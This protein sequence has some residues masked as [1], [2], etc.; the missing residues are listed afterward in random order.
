MTPRF[1]TSF[2]SSLLVLGSTA[3]AQTKAP[4]LDIPA[5]TAGLETYKKDLGNDFVVIV[6]RDGKDIYRKEFGELKATSQEAIGAAS[7]WLTAA[8]TMTFVEEGKIALDD[9]LGNYLPSYQSYS[10]GW[11]TFRQCLS[12]TTSI[13][14]DPPA[15]GAL[16]KKKKFESLEAEVNA[17]AKDRKL[18]GKQGTLF[19]YGSVGPNTAGYVLELIGKKDYDRLFRERLSKNLGLRRTSFM[20]DGLEAESPF[21]GAKSTADDYIK[22][23][24][25][26]LNKGSFNGKQVLSEKSVNEILKVQT[27]AAKMVYASPLSQGNAYGLGCWLQEKDEQGN[28]TLVNCPGVSATWPWISKSKNYAAIVFT[29]SESPEQ[30]RM[31]FEAIRELIEANLPK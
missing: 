12:H 14:Q 30:K 31:V 23:L 3:M 8:L 16:L 5:I 22:F 28:G 26:L 6:Q 21:A 10:K 29:K 17:Y 27:G 4:M 20:S 11:V 19:Y 25:M 15:F 9:K 2:L 24:S 13:E 1:L 18:Q 7:Q